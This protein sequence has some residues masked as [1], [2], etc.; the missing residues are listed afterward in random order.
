LK[1]LE[2]Y[3]FNLYNIKI[4]SV[5]DIFLDN[6]DNSNDMKIISEFLLS[7]CKSIK[8]LSYINKGEFDHD[9]QPIIAV[10][11]PLL[12]AFQEDYYREKFNTQSVHADKIEV[13][14]LDSTGFYR[15]L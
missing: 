7:R 2:D 5:V 14:V 1:Y 15:T 6:T 3:P 13:K 10:T 9:F 12:F 8:F 4:D 11:Q